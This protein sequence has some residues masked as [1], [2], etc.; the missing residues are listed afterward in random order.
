MKNE[1]GYGS[2]SLICKKDK[3]RKPYRVQIHV[4]WTDEGKPLRKT[5]GYARTRSEGRQ[6]LA[7][8]HD[9]PFDLDMNNVSFKFLYD[10]WFEY[11]K[12]TGISE[13][14]L[15]KYIYYRKHYNIIENKSFIEITRTDI[16]DIIDS[17]SSHTA[18][19]QDSIRNL[20][21]QLYEYAKGNNIKVGADVSK[22]VN[23]KKS[24]PSTLHKP[25]TDEELS[26]LWAN[27]N[28]IIDIILINIYTG[29]RPGEFFKISE[30]YDDYFV[31][32]SKT[33]A[34]KNRVIPLNNKIKAVFHEMI[35]SNI[36]KKITNE[37]R[38]YHYYKRNLKL[39]DI[40]NHSPYDC[41][42]TFATLMSNAK[43][44]EHCI[45]LIMGH[46]ISDITKRVYTHKVIEQLIDEVNKI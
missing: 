20:Y 41:R 45:K 16:Q 30:I 15:K 23:I 3:R 33:E 13:V 38:L 5:I 24:Q 46:K 22:F 44:D 18:G 29:L 6:M 34:G 43:A 10:K 11:K 27:R 35:R 9:K 40:N 26:L 8:Y 28:E 17:I 42:H 37:D 21:H 14:T 2:V 4:G 1:S 12:T 31:T 39:L 19:Y 25:F 32:G 7:E 36:L